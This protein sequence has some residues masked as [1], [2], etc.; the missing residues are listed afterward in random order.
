MLL[1]DGWAPRHGGIGWWWWTPAFLYPR[2][3]SGPQVAQAKASMCGGSRG[4]TP[5]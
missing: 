1:A 4:L 5:D 3:S 2:H